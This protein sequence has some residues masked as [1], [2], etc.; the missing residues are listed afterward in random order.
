MAVKQALLRSILPD[1]SE[2]LLVVLHD[3]RCAVLRDNQV[4]HEAA[5]DADGIDGA[6]HRFMV[7]TKDDARSNGEH[8]AKAQ[9]DHAKSQTP[10]DT[11]LTVTITPPPPTSAIPGTPA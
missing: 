2:V 11:A 4:I 7:L 10:G 5:G 3:D 1:G 9:A 6:V 8:A